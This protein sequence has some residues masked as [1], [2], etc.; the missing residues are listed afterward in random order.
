[1]DPEFL[2]WQRPAMYAL[3]TD[4][5]V[6]GRL[7][8]ELP[9]TL[10]DDLGDITVPAAFLLA[11]PGDVSDLVRSQVIGRRPHPGCA[12]AEVTML[13]HVELAAPDLPWRY[14]PVPHADG[15][16]AVRPWLVLVVGSPVEVTRLPDGRVQLSGGDFF[17]GH[18]LADTFVGR[19]AHVHSVPGR[20]FSRILCPRQ[21]EPGADYVAALVPGW[22]V[23]TAP[24]G[25]DSLVDSWS[26]GS[27]TIVLPCF[28]SWTFRTIAEE[29]DFA[30][31][32]QRLE[33]LTDAESAQLV[34][35]DFGRADVSIGP[36]PG[37]SLAMAAA[38]TVIPDPG[39]PPVT[40]P[41]PQ[42]VADAIE[43]LATDLSHDGRWVLTLPR[44][45]VPWYPGPVDGEPW[46]WPPPG[47]DVVPDGWRRQL[48]SDPRHRG[49][50]GLGAWVAIAWQDRIAEGAAQQAGAVA[51]AAQR[52][53]HLVL[54]LAAARSLWQRR[55]PTDPLAR[56]AVLSPLLGRMPVDG[57]GTALQAVAGRTPALAAGLFSSAARRVLR[58]RGPLARS[59]APGATSLGGLIQAANRCAPPQKLGDSDERIND[60]TATPD[61]RE[62]L[63]GA[64]R[65]THGQAISALGENQDTVAKLM[66]SL[67]QAGVTEELLGFLGQ[68]TPA[69][70]CQPLPDLEA[71]AGAVASGVDPTVARPVAAQR[72]LAGLTG[73]R[74]PV[75]AEPDL[76]PELDI[77]LWRFLS[78]NAPDWLLP[79]SGDIPDDRVL[80]VQSNPAFVDAFLLGANV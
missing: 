22:Q 6:G 45:D 31:I 19:W 61:R 10:H 48:R 59:A 21:L 33:P 29:G 39:Q 69:L 50:A 12:D 23:Q 16:A 56:L 43:P 77:P 11:G 24:D 60:A 14:S 57:G 32:A 46:A 41:L 9:V 3:A 72:V 25:T 2:A 26:A 53:R 78:D 52:I 62:K 15:M 49:A 34:A 30:S 5:P 27:G 18:P 44:Y 55:V 73:L 70:D 28:D 8:A 47:D 65:Q 51:A 68:T 64:L 74:E 79:G 13:A 40:D 66:A 37:T 36:L 42:P 71:F 75:L 58:R 7:R 20:R 17:A 80:A 54:G 67:N 63:A 35:R 1:M 4:P 38:L 76:A